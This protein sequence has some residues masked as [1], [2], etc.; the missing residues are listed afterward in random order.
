MRTGTHLFSERANMSVSWHGPSIALVLISAASLRGDDS[1]MK[2]RVISVTGAGEVRV[3]PD[4]A[5]IFLGTTT[6]N[7]NLSKAKK[8]NDE[9]IRALIDFLKSMNL[10]EKD[11]KTDYLSVRPVYERASYGEHLDKLVGYEITNKLTVTLKDLNKLDELITG[12]LAAGA[13]SIDN[14]SFEATRIESVRDEARR[15]AIAAARKK[16]ELYSVGL[17][18]KVGK[19]RVIREPH[20]YE[21]LDDGQGLFGG[22]GGLGGGRFIDGEASETA[23]TIIAGELVISETVSVVFDLE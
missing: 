2:P 21:Y 15:L 22:G 6:F 5:K 13:N 19:A 3:K 9:K 14:I 11:F 17:D 1:T 8:E 23:S 10:T 7:E 16:A 20:D 4:H 12:A 18:Q